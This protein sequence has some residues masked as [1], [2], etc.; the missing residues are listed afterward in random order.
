MLMATV[1]LSATYG[2]WIDTSSYCN[3]SLAADILRWKEYSTFNSYHL[4][5]VDSLDEAIALMHEIRQRNQTDPIPLY[6]LGAYYD[7][8]QDTARTEFF[9]RQA[10]QMVDHHLRP[11]PNF[12]YEIDRAF[13]LER[14]YSRETFLRAL[15]SIKARHPHENVD[16]LREVSY[17]DLFRGL[18]EG[19]CK[20]T[21]T[22]NNK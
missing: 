8:K 12:F 2:Q 5:R 18:K 20:Y 3:D 13:I 14:L 15:D 21:P 6:T 16:F 11:H 7:I 19:D 22:P 4:A 9:W 17:K 1:N 10:L